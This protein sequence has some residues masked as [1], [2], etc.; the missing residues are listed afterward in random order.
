MLKLENVTFKYK[1]GKNILNNINL[2]FNLGEII[3]IIGANG[4]GKS[5]LCNVIVNLLK[6]EGNIFLDNKNIKDIKN[7]DLRKK[8][9]IVF[10][11]PN[12]QVIFNKVYDDLYFSLENLSLDNKGKRIKEA[13]EDVGMLDY[14][15][16]NP[17][18]MSL[19]MKQRIA[20]SNQLA[21]N[22]DYYI[23][24]EITSMID[25]KG[26]K[27]IYKIIKKLKEN[28]KCVIMTTN[29]MEEL[30][31]ADKIVILDKGYVKDVIMVKDLIKKIDLLKQV[32]LEIPFIIKLLL[33]L[34][35]KGL[36]LDNLDEDTILSLI[37]ENV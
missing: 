4:S 23:F 15:D 18:E 17:Y 27:D 7:N 11:N 2:E 6:S 20:I 34:D 26:K 3:M 36:H 1:R 24:D 8:I 33:L 5:T 35:K 31:Y 25:Y 19:G 29:I 30:L 9:G 10:Q 28:K 21:I 12:N 16:K 37:E 14:I 32:N 22:P 13:L